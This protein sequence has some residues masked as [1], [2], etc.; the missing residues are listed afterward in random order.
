MKPVMKEQ[1]PTSLSPTA[2]LTRKTYEG[3]KSFALKTRPYKWLLNVLL[4]LLVC[5]VV[6]GMYSW[7][8]VAGVLLGYFLLVLFAELLPFI[9]EIPW[10]VGGVVV[11]VIMTF[12]SVV[13]LVTHPVRITEPN[14]RIALWVLLLN[15]LVGLT[16]L[17]LFRVI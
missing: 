5:V 7:T 14:N 6:G 16:A 13:D 8:A 2:G 11:W 3:A 9:V 4:C 10:I 12:T 15:V 17:I 1:E